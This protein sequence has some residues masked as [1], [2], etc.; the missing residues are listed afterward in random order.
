MCVLWLWEEGLG[1]PVLGQ[2]ALLYAQSL[3]PWIELVC[4]EEACEL[5]LV[6]CDFL[7]TPEL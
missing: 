4:A 6:E 5:W 7:G 2:C 3:A 1:A